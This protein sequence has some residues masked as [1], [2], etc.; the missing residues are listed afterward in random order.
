[1]NPKFNAP[2]LDNQWLGWMLET[3]LLGIAALL[4]LVMRATW[5]FG[6]AGRADPS[7]HGWLLAS[8]SASIFA[9]GIGMLTYDAFA[10]T[11]TVIM[12]FVLLGVGAAALRLGPDAGR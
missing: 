9:F 5:R 10:F 4:W 11:Q 8:L 6:K 12:M 1:M 3:G 7:D 2:I